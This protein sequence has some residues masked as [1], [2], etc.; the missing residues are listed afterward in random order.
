[1]RMALGK[2]SI[3]IVTGLTLCGCRR[4][5]RYPAFASFGR[6]QKV[7]LCWTLMLHL[8]SMVFAEL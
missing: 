7:V 5:G 8:G 4:Q 6:L 1:V 2:A 3:I